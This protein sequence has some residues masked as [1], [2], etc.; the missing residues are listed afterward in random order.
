MSKHIVFCADGTWNGPG[1]D[2]GPDLSP[3]ATNVLK[4][5][6]RL[7]GEVSPA[8]LRLRDEQEKSSFDVNGD[9]FQVAKYLHG[10]GDSR[11]GIIKI[12]GGV[13]GEGFVE[14]I[15]RGYT[16][17]SRNYV[18]GDR[19]HLVGFSRGAYT[20]RA[21][22]GMILAMGLLDPADVSADDGT[23]DADLA[24]RK[25]ISAWTQYRKGAGK[26]SPLLGYLSEFH[27]VDVDPASLRRCESIATIAVWDTVGALG[28]P[29]YDGND[30]TDVF[31]FADRALSPRVEIGLHAIS[32]DE[33]RAD[34][35]PTLWNKRAGV[36]QVCFAGAHADVGGGYAEAI[37]SDISLDWMIRGLRERGLNFGSQ[38][39][40]LQN[41]FGP[42]HTPWLSAPFN[43]GKQTER[44]IPDFVRFH[45][46]VQ[47]RLSGYDDYKPT[48]LTTWLK[49][50]RQL[51][52]DMLAQ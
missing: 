14:R 26:A 10:V 50:G 4:L 3:D 27:A 17:V 19:V 40:E 37:L 25:G 15:V 28:I 6:S 13:F 34:F 49:G 31:A 45:A 23:W 43:L 35:E 16:F 11:N 52:P 39:L 47:T 32:I 48:N 41:P 7:S 42:H 24:Y 44:T 22:G 18:S 29:L 21:L 9:L 46:S 20:V 1:A 33:R 8:S 2:D 30:R 5:F 38:D 51:P 12:L 36:T